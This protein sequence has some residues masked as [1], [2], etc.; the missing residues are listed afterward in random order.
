MLN[1]GY[2]DIANLD[3]KDAD[4]VRELALFHWRGSADRILHGRRKLKCNIHPADLTE[5]DIP[6]ILEE[7]LCDF[8]KNRDEIIYLDFYYRGVQPILFRTKEIRADICNKEVENNAQTIIAYKD[9]SVGNPKYINRGRNKNTV[10]GHPSEVGTETLASEISILDNYLLIANNEANNE[11]V[12]HN[13]H[14]YGH[15]YKFAIPNKRSTEENE[16]APFSIN[17]PHP[18]NA[19]AVEY[20]SAE[21]DVVTFG[22]YVTAG[23]VG[24]V[25]YCDYNVVT[26]YGIYTYRD[27][28]LY[29]ENYAYL[30]IIDNNEIAPRFRLTER[31]LFSDLD[32]L[33]LNYCPF[34]IYKNN[35]EMLGSFETTISLMNGTN[36]NRSNRSDFLEQNVQ[37]VYYIINGELVAVNSNGEYVP[38]DE[39]NIGNNDLITLYDRSGGTGGSKVDIGMLTNDTN[40]ELFDSAAEDNYNK[41]MVISG[42][43]NLINGNRQGN[44]TGQ[45]ALITSGVGTISGSMAKSASTYYV[46]SEREWLDCVIKMCK[47]REWVNM[48]NLR[49]ADIEIKLPYDKSVNIASKTASMS[50]QI[51]VGIDPYAAIANADIFDDANEIAEK[52]VDRI[53]KILFSKTET[54]NSYEI[55]D[56][57]DKNNNINSYI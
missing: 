4:V 8:E 11:L 44:T 46:A 45:A 10:S 33:I 36:N 40:T 2:V 22:C 5:S 17:V 19:F 21:M 14:L 26:Q 15:S 50:Q 9:G 41:I 28:N 43:P 37:C 24:N 55:D 48:P 3:G 29:K 7:V 12:K 32:G 52:S 23:K 6:K 1:Y 38:S 35:P 53:D 31:T 34:K 27:T 25:T 30:D 13:K 51:Q 56:I 16:L 47:A 20:D 18:C 42:T 54:D 49:I 39:V 57:Q